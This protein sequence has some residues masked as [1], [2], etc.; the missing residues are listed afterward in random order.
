ML[1]SQFFVWRKRSIPIS[2]QPGN[3][4]SYSYDCKQR[5]HCVLTTH[6][7]QLCARYSDIHRP[8]FHTHR[9]TR[10][11]RT[12]TNNVPQRLPT[13][14]RRRKAKQD[15]VVRSLDLAQRPG[16]NI[17]ASSLQ[18]TDASCITRPT[19]AP[20]V[21]ILG[22]RG[23]PGNIAHCNSTLFCGAI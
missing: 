6:L 5:R 13:V 2:E 19:Q 11:D 10:R 1:S 15:C 17:A 22:T 7:T 16:L 21:M 3:T 9:R 18:P 23:E 8:M 4:L 20:V 12:E 14:V